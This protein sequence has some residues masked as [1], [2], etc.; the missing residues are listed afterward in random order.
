MKEDP[1][2]IV[3]KHN[4]Y[5]F[6]W[7]AE[8]SPRW[9]GDDDCFTIIPEYTNKC[10]YAKVFSSYKIAAKYLYKIGDWNAAI[11]KYSDCKYI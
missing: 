10:E 9:D 5:F 11:I 2:I 7:A 6:G 8:Y 4:E 3:N 1:C